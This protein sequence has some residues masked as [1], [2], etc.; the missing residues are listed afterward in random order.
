MP[1]GTYT[2]TAAMGGQNIPLLGLA[3]TAITSNDSYTPVLVSIPQVPGAPQDLKAVSGDG[4]D[5][6]YFLDSPGESWY[7]ADYR[8]Y[9][10]LVYRETLR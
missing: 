3:G 9:H 8:L 1:E 4:E 2:A 10:L 5:H 6:A 7:W